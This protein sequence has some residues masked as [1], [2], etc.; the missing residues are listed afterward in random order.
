MPRLK[1]NLREGILALAEIWE[2]LPVELIRS[3][4]KRADICPTDDPDDQDVALPGD[5]FQDMV[6][7]EE[8]EIHTL[9]SALS[10]PDEPLSPHEYI[11]C[12]QEPTSA[13]HPA[14][15]FLPDL[16]ATLPDGT[17]NPDA[18]APNE[19]REI[20]GQD[21][22]PTASGSHSGASPTA[23]SG[24]HQS[25][26]SHGPSTGTE[27]MLPRVALTDALPALRNAR[28]FFEDNS[29]SYDV[30]FV[31]Q[32]QR[33]INAIEAKQAGLAVRARARQ[34]DIRGYFG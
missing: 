26:Q 15:F 2:N 34:S 10:Q 27:E 18:D 24:S 29:R 5:S 22:L 4:W 3:S 31:F 16:P 28:R 13:V 6:S 8:A 30:K 32:L 1:P 11:N 17:P 23:S 12:E 14:T 20:S 21:T 7:R 25:V 9:M 33:M 19:G